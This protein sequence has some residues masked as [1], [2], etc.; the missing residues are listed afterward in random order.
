[1]ALYAAAFAFVLLFVDQISKFGIGNLVFGIMGCA[2]AFVIEICGNQINL[3][4]PKSSHDAKI[5]NEKIKLWITTLNSL[6]IALLAAGFAVPIIETFRS[7]HSG[8]ENLPVV[9]LSSF[10]LLAAGG[11]VHV[12]A[13]SIFNYLKD[14]KAFELET[15]TT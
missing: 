7:P 3:Y 8:A 14:E 9:S 5:A 13:R 15:L 2:F 6:G 10:M 12:R 4:V 1:M 11:Y